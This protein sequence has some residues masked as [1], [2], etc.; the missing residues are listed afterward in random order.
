VSRTGQANVYT[1]FQWRGRS[2]VS[3]NDDAG[4][5]EVM[6]VDREWRT[7]EGRW[8]TGGYDEIGLDVRL[9]RVTVEPRVLGTERTA[10]RAGAAAQSFKIYGMNLDASLQPAQIDLGAGITV[11]GVT[12]ATGDEATI[13]V[14][15]AANATPGA[16]DLF[17]AGS[18]R[19]R[20]LAVYDSIDAI[21]VTP[22]WAMARVGGVGFPKGLAQFE[23]RAYDNGPDDRPDTPDD[24][25][26]G[27][28]PAR[29]TLEEFT[30]TYDDDDVKFVG[31]IDSESGLFTPNVDGP[32]PARR[33]SRNNIGD[34]YAV[35]TYTPQGTDGKAAKTLR[36]RAHLLVTVPLYMRWEDPGSSR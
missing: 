24:I 8:F 20:A 12:N 11:T 26:L 5:R 32:N 33:G 15:V 27:V 2:G 19:P 30:A 4:L 7:M 14:N 18:S 21:K 16:R 1:G 17:V 25:D 6:F 10:L 3:P 36:A 35:A 22:T 9:E 23:A 28:V 34:V 13:T 29:W 31:Q